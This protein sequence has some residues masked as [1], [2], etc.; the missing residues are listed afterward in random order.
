MSVWATT[1]SVS[2]S[3]RAFHFKENVDPKW[4]DPM[5]QRSAIILNLTQRRYG[6]TIALEKDQMD[7]K[8]S[9]KNQLNV[10][11]HRLKIS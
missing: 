9:T 2:G 7:L 8:E 5:K 6:A 3:I 1:T 10:L 4:I 11:D